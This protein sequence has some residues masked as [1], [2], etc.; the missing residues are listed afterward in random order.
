MSLRAS[1][2]HLSGRDWGDPTAARNLQHL[3]PLFDL[4][5]P[6]VLLTHGISSVCSH[7]PATD[8]GR[9]RGFLGCRGVDPLDV[10]GHR[11]RGW[12]HCVGLCGSAQNPPANACAPHL[13]SRG[14][15]RAGTLGCRGSDHQRKPRQALS[16]AGAHI[17]PCRKPRAALTIPETPA[18]QHSGTRAANASI[19]AGGARGRAMLSVRS[20]LPAGVLRI[21]GT[22]HLAAVSVPPGDPYGTHRPT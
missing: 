7:R 21:V 9:Q 5:G 13:R 19:H 16:E 20:L 6:D 10:S 8:H 14:P 22:M 4:F 2:G 15:P 3:C 11:G 17:S 1:L 12:A 18:V